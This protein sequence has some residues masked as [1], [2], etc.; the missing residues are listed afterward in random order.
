MTWRGISPV[1]TFFTHT[2][3]H[4][5]THTRQKDQRKSK[6]LC[7]IWGVGVKHL[8]A[9]ALECLFSYNNNYIKTFS[10]SSCSRSFWVSTNLLLSGTTTKGSIGHC[11]PTPPAAPSE[12]AFSQ[13][14][15]TIADP[16]PLGHGRYEVLRQLVHWMHTVVALHWALY[17]LITMPGTHTSFE[18]SSAPSERSKDTRL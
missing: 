11:C 1:G 4:T 16:N 7:A 9:H 3:T 5:H 10:G 6:G 15:G 13:V 12:L 17:V 14:R 2:N 8:C 18:M